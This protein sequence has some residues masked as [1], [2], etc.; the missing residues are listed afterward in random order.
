MRTDEQSVLIARIESERPNPLTRQAVF[1]RVNA[2][3]GLAGVHRTVNST[4]DFTGLVSVA[5]KQFVTV[6]WI[7]QNTCEVAERQ[8]ATATGPVRTAVMRHVERLLCANVEIVWSLRI[9]SDR[10]YRRLS[11]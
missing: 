10:V 8:I 5:R 9:T 6:A 2:R 7:D 11:R 4:A 1:F 3:P